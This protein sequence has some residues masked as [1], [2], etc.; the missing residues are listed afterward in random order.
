MPGVSFSRQ[1]AICTRS[2]FFPKEDV[3]QLLIEWIEMNLALGVSKILVYVLNVGPK[4]QAVLDYYKD[5]DVLEYYGMAWPGANPQ[6]PFLQQ[7]L[8]N[9]VLWFDTVLDHFAFHDCLYRHMYSYEMIFGKAQTIFYIGLDT[10]TLI[11][12]RN[13]LLWD[14][15]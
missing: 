9:Q 10:L 5:L 1:F 8:W 11:S 6:T 15:R 7:Y 12:L 2:L 3:F 14:I 4:I 13:D